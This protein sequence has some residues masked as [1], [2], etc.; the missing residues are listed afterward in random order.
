MSD[1]SADSTEDYQRPGK[2]N[3]Q[4]WNGL[5]F[6][7]VIYPCKSIPGANPWARRGPGK[8][9]L[10]VLRGLP[11]TSGADLGR[12]RSSRF[13][14]ALRNLSPSP[15]IGSPFDIIL[16]H[17]SLAHQPSKFLK[18]PIFINFQEQ[19]APKK[20]V[21]WSAFSK[22]RLKMPGAK[23]LSILDLDRSKIPGLVFIEI[24]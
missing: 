20:R 19:R 23:L 7:W 4:V 16:W 14:L 8:S 2:Q 5:I 13:F 1:D 22:K 6:T 18:A 21:F 9:Q 3:S 11:W 15:T 17:P 10:K 24:C 12:G